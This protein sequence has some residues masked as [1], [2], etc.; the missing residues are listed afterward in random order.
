LRISRSDE[1]LPATIGISTYA[2][3]ALGDVVYVELPEIDSH[4]NAGDTIGAVESVKSAR[5]LQL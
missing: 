3:K 5:Y 2:A 4:H 1:Q